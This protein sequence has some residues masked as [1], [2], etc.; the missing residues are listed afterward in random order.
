MLSLLS[1]VDA[2]SLWT[3]LCKTAL[4]GNYTEI[5]PRQ[6]LLRHLR[7]IITFQML[8]IKIG[9][10]VSQVMPSHIAKSWMSLLAKCVSISH[11][12]LKPFWNVV[13]W[14]NASKC[15][16]NRLMETSETGACVCQRNSLQVR[17]AFSHAG[18]ASDD[19]AMGDHDSF[20][21]ACRAAGVHDHCDIRRDRLPA[22]HHYCTQRNTF[23]SLH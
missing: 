3:Q 18:D 7:M 15:A 4:G 19:V 2:C 21:N 12:L 9:P 11:C 13:F 8:C 16:K 17:N 10:L 23:T 20:R 14:C 6:T 5:L 1:E 22:G